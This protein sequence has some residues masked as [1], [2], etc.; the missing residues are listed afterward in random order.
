[1]EVTIFTGSIQDKRKLEKANADNAMLKAII[2]YV[3]M[4]SDI[5]V[6]AMAEGENNVVS[7]D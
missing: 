2:D 7:E 3:A 5:D 6:P 4:M 1:M